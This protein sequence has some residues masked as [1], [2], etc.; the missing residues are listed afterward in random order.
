M[1]EENVKK[2][3]KNAKEKPL[4]GKRKWHPCQTSEI[5]FRA[6]VP[7]CVGV[8]EKEK[9]LTS[10]FWFAPMGVAANNPFSSIRFPLPAL[11]YQLLQALPWNISTFP[12]SSL[13]TVED[14]QLR[15]QWGMWRMVGKSRLGCVANS[16]TLISNVVRMRNSLATCHPSAFMLPS[17]YIC[18][19]L[20][21]VVVCFWATWHLVFARNSKGKKGWVVL[22]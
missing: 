21:F 17:Q 20:L 12:L 4:K 13:E 19:L 2:L 11:S 15:R 9:Y 10:S 3:W 7:V 8:W 6:C 5:K 1:E 16:M 18:C 22:A 14:D